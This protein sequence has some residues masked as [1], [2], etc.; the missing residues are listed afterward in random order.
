MTTIDAT[1][2]SSLSKL[3]NSYKSNDEE[4]KKSD[5]YLG[6]EAF[7]KMLVAQL[8]N[9]DPLNPMEGSDFSAQLAQ[10]SSLE[11]LINVNKS[12]QSMADAFQKSSETDATSFIGKE[13]TGN[14]NSVEISS[15]A[16]SGGQYTLPT[17]SEVMINITNAEGHVVKTIYPG[18]QTAGDYQLN[19]DGT[20]NGG[21][22]VADGSY[23]Y[24]V[25]SN[26]GSGYAALPTTV[27]GKVDSVSY[28][29]GK[30]YLNIGGALLSPDS[31]VKVGSPK[32]AETEKSMTALDYLGKDISYSG[33]AFAV[34]GGKLSG[35]NIKFGLESQ[36]DVTIEILD[37]KGNVVNS[38]EIGAENTVIGNNEISWNGSDAS[39]NLVSD[40]IYTYSVKSASGKANIAESGDVTGIK[41]ID[42]KQYLVAGSDGDLVSISSVTE[43]N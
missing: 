9:Q 11:Q 37:S 33:H 24:Q 41:Y 40:G 12:V 5:D 28:Q 14:A 20:D 29:N 36:E 42:G 2:N 22:V 34:E 4:K 31:V 6:R 19:W 39:G 1:G 18:Q 10:F 27:T 17:T 26:T 3:A 13:V 7:L 32:V 15:G 21:K 43:I 38:F 35:S 8:Q 25:L 23:T 16:A 30:A